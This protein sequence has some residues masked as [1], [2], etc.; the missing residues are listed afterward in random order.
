VGSM[1]AALAATSAA[2]Q[3]I[4]PGYSTTTL[5]QARQFYDFAKTYLGFYSD[6]IPDAQ[7][8][9][10]W[11]ACCLGAG[12]LTGGYF[13]RFDTSIEPCMAMHVNEADADCRTI[14]WPGLTDSAATRAQDAS[15]ALVP[16]VIIDHG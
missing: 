16:A 8:F 14:L 10:R 1:A 12:R 7:A 9:Y 3:D 6:S 15:Q 13:C 4:D 2:L 5:A 11:A